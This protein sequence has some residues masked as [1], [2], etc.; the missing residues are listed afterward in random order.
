MI[1]KQLSSFLF[2]WLISSVA[3]W[4]CLNW[5][6]H[7]TEGSEYAQNSFWFYALVGLIFSLVN[8]VVKPIATIFALPL[9][10]ATVGI[11][12]VI[13]NAAMVGLTVWLVPEVQISFGGALASCLVISIINYLVNLVVADIK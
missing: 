4:L 2:R 10:F 7:F 13:V 11:F 6:G 12:T 3:M 1:K 9:I 5:F 8:S